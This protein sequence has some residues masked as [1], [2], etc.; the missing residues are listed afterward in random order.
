MNGTSNEPVEGGHDDRRLSLEQAVHLD[1]FLDRLCANRR[2]PTQAL[3]GQ[4]LTDRLLAAQLCLVLPDV[5]TPKHTFLRS[6]ERRFSLDI[7][8]EQQHQTGVS[9]RQVLRTGARVAAAAGLAGAG[10][11]ADEALRHLHAPMQLVAGPGHWY[12]IAAAD[13]V[14]PGQMQAFTAGGVLGY[15]VKDGQHLYA[16]SALCTHMGCRLKP[17]QSPLGLRCL[18]HGARFSATGTVLAGPA[19]ESLPSIALRQ[20]GGRIFARGTVEDT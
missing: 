14:A 18:C 8:Q 3:T 9:R 1:A 12:D 6:L 17:T 20:E 15:L 10:L 5:E 4:Q 11:A 7:D 16:M 13:A 19:A 2:P